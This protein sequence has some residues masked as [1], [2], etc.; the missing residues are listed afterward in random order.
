MQHRLLEALRRLVEAVEDHDNKY[1]Q[2]LPHYHPIVE[3]ARVVI[4]ELTP[5]HASYRCCE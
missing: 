5:H 4:K 1:D 3:A 2:G